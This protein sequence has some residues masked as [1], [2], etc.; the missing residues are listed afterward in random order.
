MR[1]QR[2]A[3]TMEEDIHLRGSIKP[4]SVITPQ[5]P[6]TFENVPLHH[7]GSQGTGK[8]LPL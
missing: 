4:F 5:A 1:S 3:S 7:H 8:D 2:M 6:L